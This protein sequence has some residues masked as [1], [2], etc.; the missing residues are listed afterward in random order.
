MLKPV[1]LVVTN[2]GRG[3]EGCGGIASAL[4]FLYIYIG[5]HIRTRKIALYVYP[6]TPAL[7]GLSGSRALAP[8]KAARRP[9][10]SSHLT[11]IFRM[12]GGK[13][14]RFVTSG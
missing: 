13:D 6:I 2:E 14:G 11:P 8:S 12:A 3:K 4:Y 10:A 9:C 5:F 1:V 7:S